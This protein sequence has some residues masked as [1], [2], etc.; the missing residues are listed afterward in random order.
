[1]RQILSAILLAL[2]VACASVE[3]LTGSNPIV[4]TQGINMA[5]Y[6]RDLHECQ[7]YADQVAVAR[8]AAVGAV[9][10]AAVGGTLGA[11]VGNS[12]T[13]QR[14]AGVGAVV[15]GSRGISKGLHDRKRV[16]SRCLM[17]RGYRV[18]G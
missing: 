6:S 14:G 17:G 16:I 1:M 4:D 9:T 3:D 15:G 12:N 8:K 2:L 11:I 5:N 7:A 10:G 13:A 18:L